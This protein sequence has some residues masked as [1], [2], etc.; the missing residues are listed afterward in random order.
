MA[1]ILELHVL[2]AGHGDCLWIEYGDTHHRH[3][4]LIDGGTK[5]T[6][7]HIRDRLAALPPAERALELL[8]VTHI[9]ADHIA[10]VLE[11]IDDEALGVQYGDIWFNGYRHLPAPVIQD[12]GAVQAERLTMALL[13]KN[14]PW[15]QAFGI[16]SAVST[17]DDE[18]PVTK[19]LAGGLELTVL[20]PTR[21]QLE[22]LRPAWDQ[23]VRKAGLDPQTVPEE[24]QELPA[25]IQPMGPLNVDALADSEFNEDK[26]PANGSSI[27]LLLRYR[28]KSILLAGDAYPSTLRQSLQTLGAPNQRLSVDVFKLPH[29][30][31]RNN[32]DQEL[33]KALAC[34]QFVVSTN[35]AYFRHPDREA[36]ARI[37]KHGGADAQLAF[38]YRTKHNDIW[39]T[40][41][42]KNK[43]RYGT[44]YGDGKNPLVVPVL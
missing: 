34:R 26:A 41:K 14:L 6:Y 2:P 33:L 7:K 13:G 16:H 8:V 9:D 21:K 25:G 3:R 17:A 22:R 10:G 31:S 37:V 1:E 40:A 30:G 35:G 12:F 11:L 19:T 18:M 24:P 29:H 43:H 23:E 15:N 4:V 42:L 36:I 28:N 39:D 44:M 38:N 5:G 27:A 32:L 20:S